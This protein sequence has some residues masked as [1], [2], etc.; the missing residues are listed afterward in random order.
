M[1][2]DD[3][4]LLAVTNYHLQLLE[5]EVYGITS[6]Q[7]VAYRGVGAIERGNDSRLSIMIFTSPNQSFE[8]ERA[9]EAD[10]IE[11]GRVIK[12][13][14][15]CKMNA[16]DQLGRWWNDCEIFITEIINE[17]PKTTLIAEV[18]RL[19][20]KV[21]N[22][23]E[24]NNHD[25]NVEVVTVHKG[26]LPYQITHR[27]PKSFTK[28][29]SFTTPEFN[30]S[31]VRG[32][33]CTKIELSHEVAFGRERI[34]VLFEALSICSGRVI[35]PLLLSWR[36]EEFSCL[37][38]FH[39]ESDSNQLPS[40]L[41]EVSSFNIEN[42]K[43]FVNCY[44]AEFKVAYRETYAAWHRAYL[45][46]AAG[47]EISSLALCTAI[48]GVVKYRF[49]EVAPVTI[50]VNDELT[51]LGEILSNGDAPD[52]IVN[53]VLLH[54]EKIRES[55]PTVK[56]SLKRF[57]LVYDISGKQLSRWESLRNKIAH[58]DLLEDSAEENE[59][60]IKDYNICLT[61]FF[62]LIARSASFGLSK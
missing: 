41:D 51:R 37:E 9:G 24:S 3:Y 2:I 13:Q 59:K 39:G 33:P 29:L 15:T 45:G 43:R 60:L 6:S 35:S 20:L 56:K 11:G 46:S 36:E 30:V 62:K 48:E 28:S 52:W 8:Q 18:D 26:A 50:E 23:A 53:S 42:L 5:L 19:L 31:I 17:G 34:G 7:E 54:L 27:E 49:T 57:A 44:L 22:D 10:K 25:V 32:M 38:V 55:K 14:L 16:R 58:F 12:A 1:L 47:L 40:I 21:S 4:Q 61:I